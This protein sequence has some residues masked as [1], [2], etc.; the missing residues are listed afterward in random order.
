[1]IKC[2]VTDR[3][4]LLDYDL[5][6]APFYAVSGLFVTPDKRGGA[7]SYI[8]ILIHIYALSLSFH[9]ASNV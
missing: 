9:N 7:S 5:L 2:D 3:Y 6:L 8:Y 1:M 4:G